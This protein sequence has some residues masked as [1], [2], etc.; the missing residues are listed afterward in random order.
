MPATIDAA[1]PDVRASRPLPAVGPAA[2]PLPWWRFGIVWFALGL[3]AAVVVAAIFTAGIAIRHADPVLAVSA[4][5][6]AVG[7]GVTTSSAQAL[8]PAERA[9]NHAATPVGE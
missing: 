6:R 7:S 9:R 3:P 8:E 4:P 5:L 2:P 1:A